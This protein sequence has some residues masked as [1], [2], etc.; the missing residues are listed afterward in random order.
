MGSSDYQ[1]ICCEDWRCKKNLD[2]DIA[3]ASLQLS[4]VDG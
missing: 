4:F 3:V 1:N 2:E